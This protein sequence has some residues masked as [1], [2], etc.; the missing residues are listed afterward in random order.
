[1]TDSQHP[2]ATLTPDHVLDAV[3]A[4]GH[5]SDGRILA[6]NSYENRVYSVGIEDSTPVIVKFYRP[7][8]WSEAQ[9]LEEHSFL[10]EQ[11]EL[12]IPVVTPWK[13]EEQTLFQ[14]ANPQRTFF[15]TLFPRQ[16]GQAPSLDN[17][18]NLE[19]LGRFIG[20]IHSAGAS[21]LFQHRPSI[22]VESYAESSAL[23]L[24]ENDFLPKSLRPAYEA[25]AQEL[26]ELLPQ[27]YNTGFTPIRLHGD[28][29]VGNVLWRDDCPHFVDFDDARNGPAIQDL[30]MLLSGE[31]SERIAQLD[32]II[33]G[34][35]QFFRFDNR[36][37]SLIEPL[38]TMRLMHYAA[39][40][41]RRWDDPAFPMTFTWF[42]T[43]RYWSEHILELKEQRSAL[44][45]PPLA[46]F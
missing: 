4:L 7:N 30:W 8:R 19:I 14:W 22:D 24:L 42:N 23:F 46:L 32:A 39:W 17:L 33:E 16:G 12:E 36:E 26:M 21:R 34:Y 11:A 13:K 15:Y 44:D 43:E 1:M 5:Y 18:D 38:R 37:L 25:I 6:L 35:E 27:R 45:E 31:R 3:E 2:F 28:C 41:A 9:I 29:H 40:L 20:R 10:Q